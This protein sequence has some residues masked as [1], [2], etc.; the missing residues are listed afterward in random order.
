MTVDG[1]TIT[2]AVTDAGRLARPFDCAPAGVAL[3]PSTFYDRTDS[4]VTLA[5]PAPP[6]DA[7]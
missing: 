7:D 1:D 4:L 5:G 2:L 6:A 3:N